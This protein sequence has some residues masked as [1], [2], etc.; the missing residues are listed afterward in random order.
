MADTA[1]RLHYIG[2]TR[3]VEIKQSA[4]EG[5]AAHPERDGAKS[6]TRGATEML[7]DGHSGHSRAT[8]VGDGAPAT[9]VVKMSNQQGIKHH[10]IE[11]KLEQPNTRTEVHR[12][13]LATA[14]RSRR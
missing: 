9:A 7:V 3:L 11:T 13:A 5:S 12:G 2:E 6:E 10:S 8:V 1:E 4:W 14:T